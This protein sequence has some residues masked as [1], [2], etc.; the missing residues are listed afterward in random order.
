MNIPFDIKFRKK[1]VQMLLASVALLFAGIFSWEIYSGG[2][3]V[4]ENDIAVAG[5][6]ALEESEVETDKAAG[7]KTIESFRVVATK[8]LFSPGRSQPAL[9]ISVT[10]SEHLMGDEYVL[11]GVMILGSKRM[12]FIKQVEGQADGNVLRVEVGEMV[13][14]YRV[15]SIDK[16]VLVMKSDS[17]REKILSLFSIESTA[18]RRHTKTTQSISAYSSN[19]KG[20]PAVQPVSNSTGITQRKRGL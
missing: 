12:A 16:E 5:S 8:D 6:G 20:T 11:E 15:H 2:F 18:K 10:G 9:N 1:T 17:G 14:P 19:T 4:S 7:V 13:G 3:V